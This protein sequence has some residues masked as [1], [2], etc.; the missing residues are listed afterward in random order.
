MS[1]KSPENSGQFILSVQLLVLLLLPLPMLGFSFESH[2]SS[3]R[4]VRLVTINSESV[5][6][7]KKVSDKGK[8]KTSI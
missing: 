7:I 2:K 4:L 8:S 1:H 6:N 5:V 3:S